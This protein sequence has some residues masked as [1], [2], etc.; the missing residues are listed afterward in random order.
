VQRLLAASWSHVPKSAGRMLLLLLPAET[1][2]YA[3]NSS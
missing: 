1:R 2:Q 3:S